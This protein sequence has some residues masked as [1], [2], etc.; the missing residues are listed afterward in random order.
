MCTLHI[1]RVPSLWH[2]RGGDMAVAMMMVPL[3]LLISISS[4]AHTVCALC[5]CRHRDHHDDGG[6]VGCCYRHMPYELNAR[7]LFLI[8]CVYV[9]TVYT[10]Y[11]PNSPTVANELRTQ[12]NHI[13]QNIL[14][15]NVCACV[16]CGARLACGGAKFTQAERNIHHSMVYIYTY[17]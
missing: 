8:A 12:C 16:P 3:L 15:M 2:I 1:Y 13:S 4:C 17:K 6:G 7:G 11:L 14:Y 9:R 5:L 10:I